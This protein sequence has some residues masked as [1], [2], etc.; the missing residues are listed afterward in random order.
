MRFLKFV[1]GGFLI[2]GSL[3]LA[4]LLFIGAVA[5]D[6]LGGLILWGAIDFVAFLVGLYLIIHH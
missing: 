5:T 3:I 2:L 4:P 1:T 6:D